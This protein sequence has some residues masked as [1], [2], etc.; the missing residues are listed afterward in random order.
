MREMSTEAAYRFRF[1]PTP[2]Q[3]DL[4]TR[5][6]GCVRVVYNRARAMREAAWS[7]RKEMCGFVAT[8]AMLT[9]LKKDPEFAWLNEVSSV[10]LQQGLRHLD[11]AYRNFFFKR[12]RYPKFRR[13]DGR[14][15]AE[16]TRS[17]FTCRDGRLRLAKMAEPLDVVWS[18]E[19]PSEPS[20][21][22]VTREADGR[23]YVCC[24]VVVPAETLTGGSD[25]VGVDLGL[26]DLATLSTGE[27][28]AN[29]RH[30]AKRQKRL[31]RLQRRLAR[32]QKGSRN[33]AKARLELARAHA[34]VRHARQDHLHK[35]STRLI[36]ENQVICVE[37]LGVKGMLKSRRFSKLIG[38]AGWFELVR[39]LTYKSAWYG[40]WL[41][42]VDRF[43]PSTKTCS[44]C[45]STGYVL[46]LS[47]REWECPGCGAR[48]DRDVNA[49]IN[50]RTAGLAGIACGEDVRL[51]L[52]RHTGQFSVKQEPEL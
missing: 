3:A 9:A 32:K 2:D 45:G 29:P 47:V 44:S 39:Q 35:L 26:A 16:F 24:R 41:V 22:T 51:G 17:G 34:A 31:G 42:R 46:P 23:W 6:F 1:Y 15:S 19:L 30:L 49:A 4:L 48:H 7:E 27:K 50:I 14:Q 20:T 5:T 21:V 11:T 33:R 52:L 10:P 40:R 37:T 12:T 28:V 38:D 25:A 36:R 18:R 13:K 43:F 8:N